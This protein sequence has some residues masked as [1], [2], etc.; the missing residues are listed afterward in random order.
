MRAAALGSIKPF[1]VSVL[2]A[3]LVYALTQS[4]APVT[5]YELCLLLC[6]YSAPVTAGNF[7][8]NVLDGFY[9]GKDIGVDYSSAYIG[10]GSSTGGAECS[11][12]CGICW[13]A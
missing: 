4:A 6:S 10:R 7:V 1:G 12:A 13:A 3:V 11:L 8:V 9:D 2:G 5:W